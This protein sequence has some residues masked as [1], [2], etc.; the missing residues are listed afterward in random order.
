MKRTAIVFILSALALGAAGLFGGACTSSS[1]GKTSTETARATGTATNV[2]AT[3]VP[4]PTMPAG[5][6][7]TPG[8]AACTPVPAGTPAWTLPLPQGDPFHGV[9]GSS[10]SDV[11]AVGDL[12]TV[13]HYNG[14]A[15]SQVAVPTANHM[16][17]AFG[18]SA[19]DVT[20][21]GDAGTILHWNGSTWSAQSSGTA[22]ILRG[23]WG[24][25]AN[26]VYAM[27]DAGTLLHWNGSAWAAVTGAPVGGVS[28]RAAWGTSGSDVFVIGDAG[29]IVHWNGSAWLAQ[30]SSGA[31]LRGIWGAGGSDVYAVGYAGTVLHYNGTTWSAQSS[32]T[33]SDLYGV[34]GS[35]PTDLHAAGTL[36]AIVHSNGSTWSTVTSPTV[37]LLRGMWGS[38]AS[39]VHAVG[40]FGTVVHYADVVA[41]AELAPFDLGVWGERRLCRGRPRLDRALERIGLGEPNVRNDADA[42]DRTRHV[43]GRRVGR[44]IRRDA[45]AKSG[46]RLEPEHQLR[47]RHFL[48]NVRLRRQRSVRG[49]LARRHRPLERLGVDRA[50]HRNVARD[51]AL[52]VGAGLER[53]LCRRPIGH[54]PA[55]DGRRRMESDVERHGQHA[56]RHMGQRAGRYLRRRRRRHDSALER[57]R[58]ELA[59]VS[60]D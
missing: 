24:A 12:G 36:G 54:D 51:P 14:S 15:W 6:T 33:G 56:A 8:L 25:A 16:R 29:T 40:E 39:D 7:A 35:G 2:P 34:W 55:F 3:S 38:G 37:N 41:D 49:R 30:S 47:R 9:W 1:K 20:I 45:P 42:A 59:D 32:A 27:G 28:M 26:D 22:N 58:V 23:V 44:R 57:R 4:T 60:G 31:N 5:P 10:S 19:S 13:Y 18:F 46:L 53:S 21:V 11:Y 43:G 50:D 52:D 17:G 48:W